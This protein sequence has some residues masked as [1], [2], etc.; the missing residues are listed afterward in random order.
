MPIFHIL[1]AISQDIKI[2]RE[3]PT[4]RQI[5][6]LAD[7]GS[8]D[9]AEVFYKRKKY[10]KPRQGSYAPLRFI[11][12]LFGAD[13]TGKPIRASI[14]GFEPFFFV[15]LP[16]TKR[17]TET[18]FETKLNVILNGTNNL[19][20][21]VDVSFEKR[22]VLYGYTADADFPFAKLSVKSLCAFRAL[23]KIFLNS[24]TSAPIFE[25]R[26]EPLKVYEANLDPMLRFFHLRNIKPCGWVSTDVD[27][28]DGNP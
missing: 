24:E 1:D 6:P 2:E 9:D 18:E 14:S 12:H 21:C 25:F 19:K 11:I 28:E 26:G 16:D 8:D 10:V 23:K 17:A 7:E 20:G 5:Q 13:E 4:E 22:K 3:T 27:P 15:G